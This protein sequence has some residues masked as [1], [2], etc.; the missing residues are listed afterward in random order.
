MSDK[1]KIRLLRETG[2]RKTSRYLSKHKCNADEFKFNFKKARRSAPFPE[3][4]MRVQLL[5]GYTVEQLEYDCDSKPD[6]STVYVFVNS[7][8]STLDEYRRLPNYR[9]L[10]IY[11]AYFES[12]VHDYILEFFA[13]IN[14]AHELILQLKSQ[15][16]HS[17]P[18]V[19]KE[20]LLQSL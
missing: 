1:Q 16:R 4:E 2:V 7:S 14:H 6:E 17:E 20:C 11:K 9:Y 15:D 18:G 13:D 3:I 19:Y 12:S 10:N 5:G 8:K